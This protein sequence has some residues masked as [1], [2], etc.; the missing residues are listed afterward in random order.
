MSNVDFTKEELDII[1]QSVRYYTVYMI[2]AEK[3]G[4][5]ILDKI[6]IKLACINISNDD[7]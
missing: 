2:Q 3:E 6:K 4:Q 1:R 7:G 5:V